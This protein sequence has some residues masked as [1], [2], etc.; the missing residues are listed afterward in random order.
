MSSSGAQLSPSEL[1]GVNAAIAD[2]LTVSA[3]RMFQQYED[4]KLQTFAVK[5][6]PAW[7]DP[8][9]W[10]IR[11]LSPDRTTIVGTKNGA[12]GLQI[13]TSLDGI[14]WTSHYTWTPGSAPTTDHNAEAMRFLSTGELLVA[15]S[16]SGGYRGAVWRS[17][18]WP[19]NPATAT[20]TRVYQSPFAQLSSVPSGSYGGL[21]YDGAQTIL[22]AWYGPQANTTTA[23]TA[24]G[25]YVRKSTD[26][27]T[28]WADTFNLDT[29][30][31]AR[32]IDTD[33]LASP[34][35]YHVHSVAYDRHWN[36]W[37]LAFGD[38]SGGGNCGHLYS[39]DGGATWQTAYF[40]SGPWQSVTIYPTLD[41]ILFMGDGGEASG[42]TRLGRDPLTRGAHDPAFTHAYTVASNNTIGMGGSRND[43]AGGWTIMA[44]T[45][46][47]GTD[48]VSRLIGTV[49]GTNFHNLY[50]DATYTVTGTSGFRQ[51]VGPT[52]AGKI[53]ASSVNDGRYANAVSTLTLDAA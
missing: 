11:L 48:R 37:W 8:A 27:G 41:A 22:A 14:T 25:L 3:E 9:G 29:Y 44:M 53:L 42:I 15:T 28:T 39:L 52:A 34:N 33:G 1:A 45:Q 20:W 13:G 36:A 10:Q 51:V 5:S 23:V 43:Y 4:P 18:G 17:T 38:A 35:G 30:L 50:I 12:T 19:A 6:T 31:T 21:A 49:D 24:A 7:A 16:A 2:T 32:G 46:I 47:T 40:G 26:N